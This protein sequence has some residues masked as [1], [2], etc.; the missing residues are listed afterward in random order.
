MA[1]ILVDVCTNLS[2]T[3]RPQPWATTHCRLSQSGQTVQP[4]CH[5]LKETKL[6]NITTVTWHKRVRINTSKLNHN[7]LFFEP[8]D[9][10]VAPKASSPSSSSSEEISITCIY[11]ISGQWY[12]SRALVL[13]TNSLPWRSSYNLA[14]EL[15]SITWCNYKY[16]AQIIYGNLEV[17]TCTPHHCSRRSLSAQLAIVLDRH[18]L[19]YCRYSAI[20]KFQFSISTVSKCPWKS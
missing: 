3:A 19:R 8:V 12:N 16:I 9:S 6:R 18:P 15:M 14:A 1:S 17:M 2:G 4:C 13:N 11:H 20:A 10:P 7:T 5:C